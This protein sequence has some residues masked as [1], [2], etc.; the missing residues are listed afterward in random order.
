MRHFEGDSKLKELSPFRGRAV[1][2]VPLSEDVHCIFNTG[3]DGHIKAKQKT[4]SVKKFSSTNLKCSALSWKTCFSG[5]VTLTWHYRNRILQNSTKYTI[6]EEHKTN[7]CQRRLLH[8]EFILK[9]YNVTDEDAGEYFCQL[10]CSFMIR[11]ERE[12]IKLVTLVQPGT[13]I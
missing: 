8:A 9:I 1:G 3:R 6:T 5:P 10:Y 12:A 11:T 2:R 13:V 4:V 7:K